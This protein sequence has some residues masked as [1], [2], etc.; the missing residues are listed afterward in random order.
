[1]PRT[2]AELLDVS[3]QRAGAT[4][5]VCR[6]EQL[7]FGALRERVRVAAAALLAEG[8]APGDRVALLGIGSGLNC[9]MS[10]LIW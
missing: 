2:V 4:A 6:S 1:M 7:S 5:L 8:V 3:E 9:S 10:E